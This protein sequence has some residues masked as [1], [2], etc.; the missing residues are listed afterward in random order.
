MQKIHLPLDLKLLYYLGRF[1]CMNAYFLF[2][3][4][5]VG[6]IFS[7]IDNSII[8]YTTTASHCTDMF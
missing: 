7:P 2:D 5:N 3:S 1:Y 4:Y 8:T 6:L